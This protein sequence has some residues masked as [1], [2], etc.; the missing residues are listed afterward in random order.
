HEGRCYLSF[1]QLY[2][3]KGFTFTA[4]SNSSG[5]I[6]AI[7]GEETTWQEDLY[8]KVYCP[9]VRSEIRIIKNGVLLYRCRGPKLDYRVAEPGVYRAEVYYRPVCGK[10]RPWIYANPIYIRS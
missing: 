9:I 7:M 2:P 10:P 1:D 3:G 5:E 6:V 4:K 8:L